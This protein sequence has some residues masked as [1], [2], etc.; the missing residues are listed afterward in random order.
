MTFNGKALR[1]FRKFRGLTQLEIARRA[2]LPQSQ[3]SELE[4]GKRSPTCTT[5][6]RLASAM[7][8]KLVVT[9]RENGFHSGP[10]F[11]EEGFTIVRKKKCQSN[12]PCTRS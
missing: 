10:L 3:I 1:E 5:L 11:S 6:K 7:G 12:S 4:S 8:A 2:K 9:F